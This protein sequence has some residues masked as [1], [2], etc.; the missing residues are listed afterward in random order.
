MRISLEDTSLDFYV[1]KSFSSCGQFHIPYFH[2][3]RGDFAG[4]LEYF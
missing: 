3:F 1:Y 4:Y 2:G